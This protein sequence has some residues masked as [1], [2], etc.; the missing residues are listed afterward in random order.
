MAGLTLITGGARSGKSRHAQQLAESRPGEL[1]YVATAG[2]G[3]NEMAARVE[4]HRQARGSRWQ[5][6]EEPVDLLGSL[7]ASASGKGAVLLDCVTLWLTNM[8][9]AYGED[10][11]R[12]MASVD[13]FIDVLPALDAPLF[14]VTNE[15][16]LG[17]VPENRLARLFRDLAGETNQR[18]A[19]T[20]DQVWIVVSGIPLRVK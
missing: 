9:F 10:R 3:D 14:A 7:P 6:L 11:R 1:L 13:Q 18:L 8:L 2:V 20:A 5:T 4:L 16:G 12:I 19:A 15:V 17:I